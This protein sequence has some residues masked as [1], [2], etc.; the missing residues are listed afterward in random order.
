MPVPNWGAAY[1]CSVLELQ[2]DGATWRLLATRA[3]KDDAGDTPGI[4]VVSD[5]RNEVGYSSDRLDTSYTCG[6]GQCAN[7]VPKHLVALAS[8][9]AQR[10]LTD[11]D[12]MSIWRPG[13]GLR[14]ILFN[15]GMGAARGASGYHSIPG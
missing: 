5:L 3:T 10:K 15:T 7:D 9:L 6:N 13:P 4:S 2:A 8:R 11:D 12:E 1:V 14:S